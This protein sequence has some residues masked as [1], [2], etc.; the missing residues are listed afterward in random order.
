MYYYPI[1]V[2]EEIVSVKKS[3]E[4]LPERVALNLTDISCLDGKKAYRK[5]V[6]AFWQSVCSRFDEVRNK[7]GNWFETITLE[8]KERD[9]EIAKSFF[10]AMESVVYSTRKASSMKTQKNGKPKDVDYSQLEMN[11]EREGERTQVVAAEM[12][13]VDDFAKRTGT[14][15]TLENSTLEITQDDRMILEIKKDTEE[16]NVT[17]F[18]PLTTETGDRVEISFSNS[19]IFGVICHGFL[20]SDVYPVS[21]LAED[22]A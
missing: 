18:L 11:P 3:Y 13:Y 5:E 12:Y 7:T 14:S 19:K 6:H 21:R 4:S 9:V 17:V 1:N 10:Q 15:L 16:D 8:E 20:W 22:R 2:I